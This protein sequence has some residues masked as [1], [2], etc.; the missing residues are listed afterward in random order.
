VTNDQQWEK[1]LR[2]TCGA[3]GQLSL[4]KHQ[5]VEQEPHLATVSPRCCGAVLEE[6][7]VCPLCGSVKPSDWA[8]KNRTWPLNPPEASHV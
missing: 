6:L 2:Y 8:M 1:Q 4:I 7:R 5:G 3:C